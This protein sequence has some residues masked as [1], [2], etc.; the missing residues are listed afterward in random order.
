MDD[1][2]SVEDLVRY[3]TMHVDNEWGLRPFDIPEANRN[4][5]H[6]EFIYRFLDREGRGYITG[7]DISRMFRYLGDDFTEA[8]GETLLARAFEGRT[9][10]LREDFMFMLSTISDD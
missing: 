10:L 8:E 3:L 4:V 9:Q 2:I 1:S 7:E 6:A 5:T